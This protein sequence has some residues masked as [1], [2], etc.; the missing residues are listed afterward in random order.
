L[1]ERRTYIVD[2]QTAFDFASQ[3]QKWSVQPVSSFAAAEITKATAGAILPM[4]LP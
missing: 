2:G 3:K 1:E 4:G